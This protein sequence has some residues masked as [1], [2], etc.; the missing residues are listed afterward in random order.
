MNSEIQWFEKPLG[1]VTCNHD[2]K[3]KPVKES[4]RKKGPYPYYGASGIVDYVDGY[5]F[6]GHYLL[7]AEDGENLRTRQTPIAFMADGKFWVNN[8]AH[9]VTGNEEVTTEYLHYFLQYADIQSYLTGAVMPKLTQGNLNRIPV[10]YPEPDYQKQIVQLLGFFD[11]KID[12]NRHINQTLEAMAQA[13]FKSWFVDFDPVKAKIAAIEQGQD[14]LRAA[15]R[16]ISGKND[17]KLDQM[18]REHHDQ[19][20]ATAALFPDAME[21]SELGEIPKGWAVGT[22][23]DLCHLNPES[24]SARTLPDTV[25]YVDLA[26]A[27]V[28]EIS[29]VQSLGGKDIPS[30]AR[31]ILRYGD[32][33]VGTVRP[34]NRSFALIGEDGLTGSTGFAV[35][36]PKSAHWL[37]FV[38]LVATSEANIERL[39]HLA[40]GGAYPAVR[41][42]IVVQEDVAIP[43]KSI[44]QAFSQ[45]VKPLFAKILSNRKSAVSLAELRDTLLPK[46]LSGEISVETL[47]N[48]VAQ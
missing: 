28:G 22:L 1:E 24:W 11:R 25:R 26:N 21:E 14:P 12:L 19:L 23:A 44:V 45:H 9:I 7:I 47:M 15:M 3:R 41:P 48:E 16:A 29:E 8:H 17:A 40:D 36:R 4:E 20:A 13:I 39:A 37:E 34:G 10:R 2:G 43:T 27:K 31:R 6:D 33:I 5:L 38:H 42:E 46:L 30:R 18:P 32:T 35:L